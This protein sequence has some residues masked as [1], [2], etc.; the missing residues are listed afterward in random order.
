MLKTCVV[1]DVTLLFRFDSLFT[2]KLLVDTF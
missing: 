2:H 1:K